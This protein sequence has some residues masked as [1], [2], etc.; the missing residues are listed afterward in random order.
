[1]LLAQLHLLKTKDQLLQNRAPKI[2]A[3]IELIKQFLDTLPFTL[4]NSQK[5]AI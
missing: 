5:K 3:D 1:M 4:T 2:K